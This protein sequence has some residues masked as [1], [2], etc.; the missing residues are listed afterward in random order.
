MMMNALGETQA[1]ELSQED[2]VLVRLV[3]EAIKFPQ[4]Q[5][6]LEKHLA[7]AEAAGGWT[8]LVAA[9]KKILA[10]ARLLDQF[11]SL[12]DED[13]RVIIAILRGLDD[14]S[15]LPD[16]S[17]VV[18]PQKTGLKVAT[19]V[20]AMRC[21]NAQAGQSLSEIVAMMNNMGGDMQHV[22]GAIVQIVNGE[23]DT[24]KLCS[25]TAQVGTSIVQRV[26]EELRKRELE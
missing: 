26:L 3:V 5:P 17:N 21:G 7:L 2:A 22:S 24:D 19:L 13:R 9:I 1:S 25:N 18:D 8:D 15:D 11:D 6:T 23:R 10:G 14:F 20:M 16:A 4:Y 12:D